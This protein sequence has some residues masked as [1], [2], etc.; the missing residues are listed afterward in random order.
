[1]IES[2]VDSEWDPVP[3]VSL[4]TRSSFAYLKMIGW[5]LHPISKSS[6]PFK[7]SVVNY[8]YMSQKCKRARL[9]LGP[10]CSRP[11]LQINHLANS[12]LV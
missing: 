6:I 7:H 10:K 12:K 11:Y 2:Q 3:L 5:S 4:D 8:A 1:M 9:H